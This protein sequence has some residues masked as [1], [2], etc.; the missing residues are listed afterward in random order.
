MRFRAKRAGSQSSGVRDPGMRGHSLHGNREIPEPTVMAPAVTVRAVEARSR[1]T[2]M[3]GPGKS[4]N[5]V[6]PEKPTNTSAPVA[7]AELVEGR[8]LPMSNSAQPPVTGA[9]HPGQA[10]SGLSRIREAARK[11]GKQRFTSLMHHITPGMLRD[12]YW[13]L[14]RQAAPGVDGV[15]WDAYGEDLDQNLVD[16]HTRIHHGRYQALPSKRV[17]IPKPDG[18]QRPLGI[19]V[20]EDKMVQTAANWVLQA[21]FEE[22]FT[23]FSYGFR[24]GR[25]Q[26]QALDAVWVGIKQRPVEWIVDADI[27]GFFDTLSHEWLMRFLEHRVADPRMLRLIRGWLRAGVVEQGQRKKTTTGTPQGAVISPLR[28]NLYL[29]HVFDLWAAWWRKHCAAGTVI[30]V[31][32]ADDFVVGFQHQTEAQA[33]LHDLRERLHRFGL[34][35]H[36]DKTRLIEFGRH[37]CARRAKRGEGKPETFDFLGF[38]HLC[39][40]TRS[41][42]GFMIHRRTVAKRMRDAI[43]RIKEKL[44]HHM[45]R[46]LDEQGQW[47]R[48]VVQG[49]FAYHAVPGNGERLCAFRH[50]VGKIWGAMLRRR[51]QRKP[52]PWQVIATLV[53]RWM[54]SARTLHPYPD[55]RLI[56]RCSW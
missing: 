2:A 13:S 26:H 54:P 28:A 5:G 3:H 56:V 8:P 25:S 1:T 45:N 7:D 20:V 41:G 29:H 14:K 48:S 31:R 36:P 55:Q 22:D 32:Y 46:T 30:I 11:D 6:V 43:H 15:T 9:Q 38:T 37:A 50:W 42:A 44:R 18:R 19:A 33:F 21:I 40:K 23:G 35:L 51:G 39:G 34:E 10:L 53:K 12:A 16:L 47:I 27:R 4:D 17:W 24:P 52:L 49:Y